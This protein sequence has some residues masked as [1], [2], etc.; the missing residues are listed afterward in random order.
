ME[1]NI[2]PIE[3]DAMAWEVINSISQRRVCI[4]SKQLTTF[5]RNTGHYL[6]TEKGNQKTNIIDQGDKKTYYF[7]L[8]AIKELFIHLENCRLEKSV[9]HFS[10]RQY[11][12]DVEY[13]GIMIDF[14]I[15][16]VERCP[17]LLDKHYFKISQVIMR[18]LVTDLEITSDEFKF[19][20]CF[21]IKS[22]TV[23]IAA[24]ATKE[25][26]A[27]TLYKYGFHILI[28]GIMVK[29]DYKKYLFQ[30]L[31]SNKII[32]GILLELG[33]IDTEDNPITDCLDQNSASV[34][35]L[36][37][38]S[39]KRSGIP[40]NIGAF[41]EIVADSPYDFP[42]INKIL[43][44]DLEKY[45]MVAELCLTIEANYTYEGNIEFF[46]NENINNKKSPLIIKKKYDINASSPFTESITL[47]DQ[48]KLQDE[49]LLIEGMND[50]SLSTLTLHNAEARYIHALLDLLD[51]SY[52]TDRNKWRNVIY[53]LA[54]TNVNYRPIAVWFSMKSIE[55]YS[56]S[57]LDTMW[58][59]AISTKNMETPL[60][61]RSI[62]YWA[63]LCNPTLYKTIMSRTYFTILS[64]YVYEH[65]G[66]IQHYMIAK[67]LHLMIGKKFCV[68]VDSTGHYCWFEFVIPNQT[69]KMG[70][71]WKWRKEVEPDD[72]YI[73]ISE[74]I[75]TIVSKINE[76]L[77]EMK[78]GAKDENTAKY[79]VK[80]QK[81][82][83]R[84]KKLLYNNTF[85]N[86]V[87]SESK[88]IFRVRGFYDKLDS[89]PFLFGVANGVLKIGK[90]CKLINQFH[91][92]PISRYTSIN[93]KPHNST[94]YWTAIVFNAICDIIP[95]PDA[96]DWILYHASLGLSSGPKN[97]LLLCFVGGGSNGKTS[98]LRWIAK[99]LHPYADKFNIQLMSSGRE[100]ADKPNSAMMK[101]KHLNWAYSEE[102]NKSQSL[103][104]ARMKEMV[105]AGEVSGREL[106]SKQETFTMKCNF[107]A[108]SQ[109]DFIID[110]TDHGTWRRIRHYTAKSKFV[111]NPEASNPFEKKE[112]HRFVTEYP[113]NPEFLSGVL[114]ILTHYYEKLQNEYNGELKSIRS[115]TIEAETDIFRISQDSLFRWIYQ[116]I[117]VSP[118]C[119][120]TYLI[121][122]LAGFYAMWYNKNVSQKDHVMGEVIKELE[123]SA[124]SKYI[125]KL[126]TGVCVVKGCRLLNLSESTELTE[127][128]KL[129]SG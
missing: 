128:E 48:N 54:N 72:I 104:V 77:E 125:K 12:S 124:L 89:I 33:A 123:S 117:V 79:Y 42:I 20:I 122:D 126:K 22:A 107:V 115:P 24:V 74:K 29:K 103:N 114:S 66:D 101:F 100:D 13:S 17:V 102:S 113:D 15:K 119:E 45:N 65:E 105:N 40:Y 118:N 85:K 82:F 7:D 80:V 34:P 55:K 116:N 90:K 28:P 10:E 76:H 5:L 11:S 83:S 110:T 2:S 99:T 56:E 58:D 86:G 37:L 69:M 57:A 63:K 81:N 112:D 127:G 67:I 59:E 91:E 8:N 106:N 93:W 96:R 75:P 88:R 30:K 71:V 46:N 52:Y 36:F 1:D 49:D 9:M 87:I 61:I 26:N 39:C 68:D 18:Q 25:A 50:N 95:E 4:G 31:K 47:Q 27:T 84:F 92:Y 98:F 35:V 64:E 70:E 38:G 73:Y 62:I 32:N 44:S 78:N 94:D 16:T 41:L 129:M 14:D 43:P 121:S 111:K 53:A 19:H 51:S 108:A 97:A 21:T 23:E 6:V 109:Y 60:T 120:E 3:A